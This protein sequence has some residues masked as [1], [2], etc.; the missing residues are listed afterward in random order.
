M[1]GKLFAAFRPPRHDVSAPVPRPTTPDAP[2]GPQPLIQYPSTTWLD[3]GSIRTV[4]DI[5]ANTGDFAITMARRFPEA[6]VI[7]FEP[8]AEAGAELE[9]RTAGEPRCLTMR[10]AL[11][12]TDAELD[13]LRCVYSPSSSILPMANLHRESFPFTAGEA[14]PERTRVRRLDDV[15]AELDLRDEILIKIDVQGYEA[16]VIRGGET[17]LR[18]ARTIIVET[19]FATLYE[20]QPRFDDIYQSLRRLGFSY[21]GNWEQLPDPRT[22]RILQADAIFIR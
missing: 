15:A 5:G 3:A 19:S 6:R 16:H 20:G 21:A 2:A 4:L 14:V 13:I 17:T 9:R 10:C 18:R 22:G 8:L 12:D 7:S 1:I 11:G